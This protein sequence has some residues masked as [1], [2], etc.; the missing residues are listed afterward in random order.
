MSSGMSGTM[1]RE[2][3]IQPG[4]SAEI[5]LGPSMLTVEAVVGA[6][7]L[8][9]A[10]GGDGAGEEADSAAVAEGFHRDR[11]PGPLGHQTTDRP[12]VPLHHRDQRRRS[13]EIRLQV[14]HVPGEHVQ[15]PPLIGR[16]PISRHIR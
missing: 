11:G 8:E 12:H 16:H 1:S 10:G 14:V 4:C 5:R 9:A 15:R 2:G 7:I 13:I 6:A 3:L